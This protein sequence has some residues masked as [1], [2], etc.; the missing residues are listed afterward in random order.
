M[1]DI[2]G[3][4]DIRKVVAEWRVLLIEDEPDNLEAISLLL[5]FCGADVHTA[6]DGEAGLK[7][8]EELKPTFV[9]SDLSMPGIDGWEMIRRLQENEMLKRIPVIA[10][11][12]HAMAGDREK[13]LQAGFVGYYS[14]PLDPVQFLPSI[15][16]WYRETIEKEK[17]RDAAN[18]TQPHP[19]PVSLAP[20]ANSL[21]GEDDH[22]SKDT[23]GPRDNDGAATVAALARPDVAIQI[24]PTSELQAV[25]PNSRQHEDINK[26]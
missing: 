6:S 20:R 26:K 8:A 10:L 2:P 11:T 9:L 19:A 24:E 25:K 16:K 23:P 3:M 15:V 14:K 1:M 7:M 13:I 5:R 22:S 17:G 12:A 21:K 4:Q 18:N